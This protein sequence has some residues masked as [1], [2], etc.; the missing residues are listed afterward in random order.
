MS[1]QEAKTNFVVEVAKELFLSRSISSVTIKDIAL[2]A[3]VG[4]MTIYRYFGRKQNIVLAVA[5]KLQQQIAKY[6]DTSIGQSGYE[7]LTIFYQ[8][9]LKIFLDSPNLYSFIYEFD[10]YMQ[11]NQVDDVLQNYEDSLLPY[12]KTYLEA[13]ELGLKDG[14][15]K[16]QNDIE[17]FYYTTTHALIEL[18]KKLSRGSGLL[19]QD[20]RIDK[21]K[22]VN[23]LISIFLQFL[24]NS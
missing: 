8:S 15:I 24:K 18:C 22:E 12:K 6:F 16:K 9:Y 14:T 4:E 23:T 21:Q 2:E 3:K 17:S 13:Y 5:I 20:K 1:L 7:K 19:Q 11:D 10:S